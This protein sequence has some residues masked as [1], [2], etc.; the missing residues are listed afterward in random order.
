MNTSWNLPRTQRK[1]VS[2][3]AYAGLRTD[4]C[5]SSTSQESGFYLYWGYQWH[6]D[7]YYFWKKASPDD[8]VPIPMVILQCW[9]YWIEQTFVVWSCKSK[10]NCMCSAWSQLGAGSKRNQ[11]CMRVCTSELPRADLSGYEDW[12]LQ[13]ICKYRVII[14]HDWQFKF[15]LQ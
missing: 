10:P 12:H 1:P 6:I 15:A 2:W 4:Q 9:Q 3:T 13:W 11:Y 7:V 14:K 5:L 8:K